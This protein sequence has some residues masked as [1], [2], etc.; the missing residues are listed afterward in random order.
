[1]DKRIIDYPEASELEEDDY[2]ILE[3]V[4]GGTCKI[5]AKELEPTGGEDNAQNN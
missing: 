4:N 2:L 5:L 3:S 1:M